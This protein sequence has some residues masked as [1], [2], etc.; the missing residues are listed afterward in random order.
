LKSKISYSRQ[1]E[2]G[3]LR[4]KIEWSFKQPNPSV[5]ILKMWLTGLSSCRN[6]RIKKI[7]EIV[8]TSLRKAAVCEDVKGPSV[9]GVL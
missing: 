7:A 1:D 8:E 2:Y 4:K 6:E 5:S 9:K 3:E